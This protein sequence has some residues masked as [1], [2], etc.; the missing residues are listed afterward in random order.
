M[1]NETSTGPPVSAAAATSRTCA[2]QSESPPCATMIVPIL[3]ALGFVLAAPDALCASATVGMLARTN[4]AATA[5]LIAGRDTRQRSCN[6]TTGRARLLKPTEPYP[7]IPIKSIGIGFRSGH[8][9][10]PERQTRLTRERQAGHGWGGIRTP[11]TLSRI[12]AFQAGRTPDH[13]ITSGFHR[14]D[15]RSAALSRPRWR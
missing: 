1:R 5:S 12:H 11:D 2:F 7:A 8:G 4:M 6:V 9:C 3:G 14:T 15:A 13:G 10:E